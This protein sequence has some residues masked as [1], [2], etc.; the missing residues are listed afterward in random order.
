MV[1]LSVGAMLNSFG[2]KSQIHRR[3]SQFKFSHWLSLLNVSRV[4]PGGVSLCALSCSHQGHHREFF[5]TLSF[6]VWVM[7]GT[8]EWNSEVRSCVCVV[9][10]ERCHCSCTTGPPWATSARKYTA[11]GVSAA[12]HTEVVTACISRAHHL[13]S[14]DQSFIHGETGFTR[15][16]CSLFAT[17]PYRLSL[18]SLFVQGM[19]VVVTEGKNFLCIFEI[20]LFPC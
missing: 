1:L 19:P 12:S 7:C 3:L 20:C 18:I 16:A 17:M 4:V 14:R 13:G 6:A 10:E 5:H 15:C 11:Q 9:P 8:G 2:Q